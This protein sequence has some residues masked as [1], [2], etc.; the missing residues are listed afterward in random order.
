MTE[1][2]ETENKHSQ[3]YVKDLFQTWTNGRATLQMEAV[4]LEIKIRCIK[5]DHK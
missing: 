1:T 5:P 3:S 2:T 4:I